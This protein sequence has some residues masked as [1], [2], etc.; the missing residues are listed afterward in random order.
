M[1]MTLITISLILNL[2][3]LGLTVYL[4]HILLS[5]KKRFDESIVATIYDENFDS[6]MK[7]VLSAQQK[8]YNSGLTGPAALKE[9]KKLHD[10]R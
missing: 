10:I 4:Y 2:I 6:M 1:E 3:C 8:L 9:A 5:F 7:S